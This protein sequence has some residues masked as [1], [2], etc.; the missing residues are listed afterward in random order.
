ML[1][2]NVTHQ[3]SET[4]VLSDPWS[5]VLTAMEW[6]L[7]CHSECSFCQDLGVS[8]K[9]RCEVVTAPPV[10]FML[11]PLGAPIPLQA[12]LLSPSLHPGPRALSSH[13]G[14]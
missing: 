10:T 14:S 11:L 8:L 9:G 4:P 5:K 3:V 12:V 2:A 13:V 7:F 1:P 6:K